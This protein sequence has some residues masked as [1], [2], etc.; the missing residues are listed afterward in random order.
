M[1]I[2]DAVQ[3]EQSLQVVSYWYVDISEQLKYRR[4]KLQHIEKCPE[5]PLCVEFLRQTSQKAPMQ[6][7]QR[8][9]RR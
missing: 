9:D 2:Q 4:L 8:T 5:K 1:S 7:T 6:L 3:I